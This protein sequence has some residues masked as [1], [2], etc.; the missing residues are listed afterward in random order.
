MQSIETEDSK[1]LNQWVV[2]NRLLFIYKAAGAALAALCFVLGVVCLVLANQDP[3]VVVASERDHIFLMGQR[4]DVDIQERDVS[5][6]IERYVRLYYEWPTL[7]PDKVI[8]HLAP[9]ITN[10]FRSS[11]LDF[12]KVRKQRDFGGKAIRQDITGMKVEITKNS[13]VAIFDVILRVDG[14]PLVVP[15]QM[16]FQLV[17][18]TATESNPL[19]LYVNGTTVH[20]GK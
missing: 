20:E 13:T 5:R 7:E 1:P 12:L 10:E 18:G 3:I 19:G 17:Q 9:F 16:S 14:I 6:F 15:T 8:S 4:K 2:L 11:A